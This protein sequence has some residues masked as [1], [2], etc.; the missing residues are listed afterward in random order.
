MGVRVNCPPLCSGS[1]IYGTTLT[2]TSL[3]PQTDT[4]GL[5]SQ[6]YWVR[7]Q[8]VPQDSGTHGIDQMCVRAPVVL[9]RSF[10]PECTL[11]FGAPFF[12]GKKR[13]NELH[14]SYSGLDDHGTGSWHRSLGRTPSSVVCFVLTPCLSLTRIPVTHPGL[15]TSV[16][17]T[18]YYKSHFSSFIRGR[19]NPEHKEH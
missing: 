19:E 3:R 11:E 10:C 15:R 12:S 4:K 16:D 18:T 1:Q 7:I 8:V 6:L 14:P 5:Q 9:G 13:Q 17:I 2:S